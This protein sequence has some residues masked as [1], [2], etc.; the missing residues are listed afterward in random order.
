[1]SPVPAKL[2]IWSAP[3]KK[4]KMKIC[5]LEGCEKIVAKKI[6]CSAH[7]QQQL[8]GGVESLKIVNYPTICSHEGC[9]K[10]KPLVRGY[11]SKHYEWYVRRGQP[12]WH[13]YNVGVCTVAG[14]ERKVGHIAHVCKGHR[15]IMD[16]YNLSAIQLSQLY[17]IWDFKCATCDDQSILCVDH[18]RKCCK[19]AGSCGNCVR[20][21]MCVSCN[22]AIGGFGEDLSVIESAIRY[23]ARPPLKGFDEVSGEAPSIPADR[24]RWYK[25][26]IDSSLYQKLLDEC[27]GKCSICKKDKR[28]LCVDHD[29]NSGLV[30]GLLC[31]QCN[32]AL[33]QSKDDGFIMKRYI[34]Y[35]SGVEDESI[36]ASS[37]SVPELLAQPSVMA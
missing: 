23:L 4:G 24:R 12:K 11:C 3:N 21:V 27:D 19:G 10:T 17:I 2:L 16:R 1:M 33:G 18:D 37:A 30:R 34:K 20:G 9:S 6:W 5:D 22:S 8:K 35:L 25:Y 29:H 28:K 13:Q 15:S 32:L 7:Y 14:C 36:S 26:G 31:I